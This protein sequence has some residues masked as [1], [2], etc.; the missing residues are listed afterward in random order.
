[1]QDLIGQAIDR[2]RMIY[3]VGYNR[4]TADHLT[5][6]KPLNNDSGYPEGERMRP[7][8]YPAA[9]EPARLANNCQ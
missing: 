6:G 3:I 8:D 4:K 5:A 2:E 1:M 9:D 7:K